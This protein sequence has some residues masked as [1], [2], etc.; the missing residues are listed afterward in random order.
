MGHDS[1]EAEFEP[2]GLAKIFFSDIQSVTLSYHTPSPMHFN[3]EL[4]KTLSIY[5]VIAIL[6]L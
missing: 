3:T 1:K 2:P 5:N 6:D 4:T